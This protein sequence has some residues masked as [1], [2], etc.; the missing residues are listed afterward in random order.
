[1]TFDNL[2]D[3]LIESSSRDSVS[4]S[5][6]LFLPELILCGTVVALLFLRLINLDKILRP[7]TVSF[8]G[9]LLALIVA[10]KEYYDLAGG[11]QTPM[12]LFTGLVLYDQFTV[13]FRLFLT[14]FVVLVTALTAL[15][16]IPDY[17]DGPDFYTLLFGAD[18]HAADGGRQ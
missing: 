10:G 17:E 13:F 4:A 15:S 16:G 2:L 6:I 9:G 1:M 8:I 5:V 3:R 18:R 7:V 11:E 14:T 12:P